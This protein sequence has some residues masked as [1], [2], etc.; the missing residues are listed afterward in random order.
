MVAGV[1][2]W[3]AGARAHNAAQNCTA[4]SEMRKVI[5]VATLLRVSFLKAR[6]P[7]EHRLLGRCQVTD[8][9]VYVLD[10]PCGLLAR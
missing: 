4:L 1:W 8:A 10:A 6:R 3:A 9:R 7:S 5:T 2:P